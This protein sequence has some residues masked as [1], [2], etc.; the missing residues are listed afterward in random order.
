MKIDHVRFCVKNAQSTRDWFI[1]Y[2]GFVSIG[3]CLSR[4]IRFEAVQA[5]AIVFVLCSS[6]NS[7]NQVAKFLQQHPPGVWDVVFQVENLQQQVERAIAQGAK[8]LQPIQQETQANGVLRWAVIGAIGDLVHTLV[9]RHGITSLLPNAETMLALDESLLQAKNT[10]LL[11]VDHV[12]LNV[13]TGQL[14]PVVDWYGKVLGFKPQQKFAIQTPYSGLCSRVLV[15]PE[16]GTQMPV[17]QPT[18]PRSQIQEFLDV[19]RGVGV[20]HIALETRDLQATIQQF[21]QRQIPLLKVPEHYY[22]ALAKRMGNA[23]SAVQ[24]SAIAA[25]QIL[26]DWH[27]NEPTALLQQTFTEP[28]FSEPTFFFELIQRQTIAN[29]GQTN[30]AY[31]F[32]EGNFQ[33]L[34]EAMEQEQL[35]RGSLL[36]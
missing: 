31:G 10:H 33:A 15:H 4:G 14:E 30:R 18:S 2:L 3:S 23:L 11:Q 29:N 6:A 12:V 27:P 9:E 1:N 19:N 24:L 32:G 7:A 5:G 36:A 28:I 8:L 35:R 20:Q 17:N 21:R 22:T 13:P 16:S 26:V 34:F 25:H